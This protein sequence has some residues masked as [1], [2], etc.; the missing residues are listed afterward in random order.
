MGGSGY[1]DPVAIVR[2]IAPKIEAYKDGDSSTTAITVYRRI[3]KCTNLP[4][5]SGWGR[6]GVWTCTGIDVPPG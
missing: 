4:C 6:G 1:I 5:Q 3:W 2:D